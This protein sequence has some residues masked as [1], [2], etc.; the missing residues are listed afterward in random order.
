MRL[1]LFF[2]ILLVIGTTISYAQKSSLIGTWKLISGKATINDSTVSYGSS[3]SDAMKIVT[4]THFA[5]IAK[6]PADGSMQHTT[7]G[8]VKMDNTHYT[9][10]LDYA[11]S[12]DMVSKTASFT[13]KVVGNKWYVKGGNDQMK[14]DEVW[15]RVQ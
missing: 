6:N 4:P 12:K 2:F 11:S 9:E 3:N 13:Y 1:K 10:Y 15:E 8:R 7:A 14:F 5:V